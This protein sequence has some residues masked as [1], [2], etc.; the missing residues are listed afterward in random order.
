MQTLF[1]CL[2]NEDKNCKEFYISRHYFNTKK[3]ATSEQTTKIELVLEQN[4][5]GHRGQNFK[6]QHLKVA[7]K[8]DLATTIT[9][10]SKSTINLSHCYIQL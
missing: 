6:W 4:T 7:N 1:Y 5:I 9:E 3:T 10:R 2:Q 8:R